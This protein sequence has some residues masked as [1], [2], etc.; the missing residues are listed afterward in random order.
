[1][2]TEERCNF[3]DICGL[4]P[5]GPNPTCILHNSQ[6]KSKWQEFNIIFQHLLKNGHSNFQKVYFPDSSTSFQNKTFIDDLDFTGATF[7][8]ELQLRNV[9]LKKG[10]KISSCQ[11]SGI[12]LLGVTVEGEV[13]IKQTR[14]RHLQIVVREDSTFRGPLVI[15][16]T[17]AGNLSFSNSKFENQLIVKFKEL[18]NIEIWAAEIH[19][20]FDIQDCSI[21]QTLNLEKVIF[22]PKSEVNLCSSSIRVGILMGGKT[23]PGVLRIDGLKV[24]GFS[25]LASP[26]DSPFPM[27]IISEKKAPIFDWE[28][29]VRFQNVDLSECLLLGNN[30]KNFQL[31]NVQWAWVGQPRPKFL[32]SRF[33]RSGLKD[34]KI[35]REKKEKNMSLIR[36][37]RE[38]YEI[39][40]KE[41]EAKGNHLQSGLFHYGEMEMRRREYS[42]PKRY[43]GLE[44]FYWILSGYGIGWGRALLWIILIILIPAYIYYWDNLDNT[45]YDGWDW[46]RHSFQ[47]TTFQKPNL[48]KGLEP[49]DCTKWTQT[50]QSVLGPFQI[51]LFGLAVRTRIKR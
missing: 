1:M 13:E 27:K 38:A 40:K 33:G 10:L 37:L 48:P 34:E 23:N 9:T 39:L 29:G 43:L 19:S 36:N 30:F 45:Y 49:S 3:F 12:L 41:Y 15:E 35:L 28:K 50:I 20:L 17:T 16:S 18:S 5:E 14:A 31:N 24:N 6:N 46:L 11:L 44:A 42:F 51:A 4:P 22:G 21:G 8:G 2:S 7:E 32:G 47:V 26:M 25:K